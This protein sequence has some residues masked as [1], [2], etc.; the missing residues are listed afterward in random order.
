[1]CNGCL[2]PIAFKVKKVKNEVEKEAVKGF[3][4]NMEE[5][6][7]RG[8]KLEDYFIWNFEGK[9]LLD[10]CF[11]PCAVGH[12]VLQPVEHFTQLNDMSESDASELILI[13]QRVFKL[14]EDCLKSKNY[15]PER[16]YL[17]SFNESPDWHLHFHIVPRAKQEDI[18]GPRL[19]ANSRREI[20]S[21]EVK[22][23]VKSLR[24]K[25]STR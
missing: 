3:L 25:L 11:E 9:F 5:K 10:H 15:P 13:A 21:E 18:V 8:L 2:L 22:S 4:K 14:L 7:P 23:V 24:E 20:T 17:C 6:D 12:L 1:M 19:M 16:I